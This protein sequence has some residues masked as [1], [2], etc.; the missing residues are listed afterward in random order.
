MGVFS[1]KK[2]TE[3]SLNS[4]ICNAATKR[5]RLNEFKNTEKQQGFLTA[6]NAPCRPLCW[7][8]TSD[9]NQQINHSV[10]V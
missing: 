10:R 9:T 2:K 4:N 7:V 6:A 3:N 8:P 1:L 5:K